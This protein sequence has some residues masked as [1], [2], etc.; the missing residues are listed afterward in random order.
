MNCTTAVI[1]LCD[2]IGILK[3]VLFLKQTRFSCIYNKCVN[4][5]VR[6]LNHYIFV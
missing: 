5:K 6:E 4:M 1:R 2:Y 3:M